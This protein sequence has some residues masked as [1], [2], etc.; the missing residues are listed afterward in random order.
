M[1]GNKNY[2]VKPANEYVLIYKNESNTFSNKRDL[3]KLFKNNWGKK[4]R[5]S[6]LPEMEDNVLVDFFSKQLQ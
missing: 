6:E 3:R 2:T 5:K 4:I 1:I